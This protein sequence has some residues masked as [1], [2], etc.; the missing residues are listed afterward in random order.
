[1][2]D[3]RLTGGGSAKRLRNVLRKPYMAFMETDLVSHEALES[4]DSSTCFGNTM[5]TYHRLGA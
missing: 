2:Y 3:G 1:M 4:F 5:L